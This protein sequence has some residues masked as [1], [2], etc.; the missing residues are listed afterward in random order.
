MRHLFAAAL[1][2]IPASAHGQALSGTVR[3]VDG[4][5]LVMT[6]TRIRLFGIDAPETA[7]TC[8]RAGEAWACGSDAAAVLSGMVVGKQVSCTQ[9]DRDDY[10]RVVAT[11]V[12][13]RVDI[14]AEMVGAGYAIAYLHYSDAYLPNEARAKA[15]GIGIWGSQFDEPAAWRAAHNASEPVRQAAPVGGGA[16]GTATAAASAPARAPVEV[17]YRNCDAARA[18]GAAPLY[19][20]DPGY[21]SAMDSDD[22]GVACE[23]YRGRS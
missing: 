21:R 22:D 14:A 7:Q 19:R 9:L 20:G 10:G 5:T 1:L 3:A 13:G 12:V 11:C 23:P 18:A 17:Y 15:L 6:G 16:V 2:L 4:D 8:S